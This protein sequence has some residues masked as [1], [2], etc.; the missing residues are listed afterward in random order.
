M[1]SASSN[2]ADI[3]TKPGAIP[4][5]A[6]RPGPRR[7]FSLFRGAGPPAPPARRRR[8]RRRKPFD[9]WGPITRPYL[10]LRAPC[11]AGMELRPLN[12][13]R[14]SLAVD[15]RNRYGGIIDLRGRVCQAYCPRDGGFTDDSA[16]GCDRTS[17]ARYTRIRGCGPATWRGTK[18][19]PAP[20][21]TRS[22]TS[23]R[24]THIRCSGR[25]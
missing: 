23:R 5:P 2:P 17:T 14:K 1:S 4:A 18:F 8:G 3:L 11:P 13:R 7:A 15:V 6:R 24:R 10:Y 12:G 20:S 19:A 9:R 16:R 22:R 21:R 25:S